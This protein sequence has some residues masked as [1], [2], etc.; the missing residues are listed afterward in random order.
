MV[1]F[2]SGGPDLSLVESIRRASSLDDACQRAFREMAPQLS[3][4]VKDG[5]NQFHEINIG[6]QLMK[7]GGDNPSSFFLID[8]NSRSAPL[9]IQAVY[10]EHKWEV[11]LEANLKA[12]VTLGSSFEV[13][14]VE[15]IRGVRPMQGQ[16]QRSLPH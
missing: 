5:S 7:I 1:W 14:G 12:K 15:Q 11:M 8:G 9:D 6:P 10:N 16:R 2:L 4:L 3:A 13:L